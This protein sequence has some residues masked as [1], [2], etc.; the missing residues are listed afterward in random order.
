MIYKHNKMICK[1][2]V[3]TEQQDKSLIDTYLHFVQY[4]HF[5]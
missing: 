2:I 3:Q 4:L 1:K 5:V